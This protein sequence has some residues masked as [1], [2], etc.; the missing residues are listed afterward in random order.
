MQL[1]FEGEIMKELKIFPEC[2]GHIESIVISFT[3]CE[4]FFSNMGL[5]K[6]SID[7]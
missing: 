7:L 2:D 1:K 4:S 5:P 3:K 6:V